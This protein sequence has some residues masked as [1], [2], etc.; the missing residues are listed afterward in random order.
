MPRDYKH[1]YRSRCIYHITMSKASGIAFFSRITGTPEKPVVELTPLGRIIEKQIWNFTFICPALRILQ[2]VIMPDHVHLAIFAQEELP[3]AIGSYIG[4]M[5]VKTGQIAKEHLAIVPP[6]FEPDFFDRILRRTHKLDTICEYI[7]KNPKRL[8]ERRQNPVFFRRVNNIRINDT[9]WQAYGN[10][11][12]L[13]NPFKAPVV[14]H[15]RDSEKIIAAKHRRWKHLSE[16]GGVLVSP[17]ISPA[18]KE[19][20]GQCEENNGKIILLSTKPFGEREKPAAHDFEQCTAGKLLI[21]APMSPLPS[22][23]ETF[24]YLNFIAESIAINSRDI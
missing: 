24:L 1:D 14:I 11:Q 7:R 3:R 9:L 20:R 16:N 21:L 23:R 15:R 17:F 10:L 13:Q 4:M 12:L 8:L 22:G 6:V 18:E 19:V 2:Y 5:K